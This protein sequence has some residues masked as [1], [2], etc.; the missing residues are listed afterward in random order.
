[1]P[2]REDAGMQWRRKG[3]DA[4]QHTVAEATAVPQK[5]PGGTFR[6][7]D[8]DEGCLAADGVREN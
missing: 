8:S 2:F 7:P 6:R 4:P 1:M 5:G 3:V